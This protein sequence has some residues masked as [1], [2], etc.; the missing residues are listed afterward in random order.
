MVSN[1][2]L[3]PPVESWALHSPMAGSSSLAGTYGLAS[4]AGSAPPPPQPPRTGA[5][6]VNETGWFKTVLA[7]YKPAEPVIRH[8]C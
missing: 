5:S 2:K 4:P 3:A 7:I 8:R 1:S 6:L